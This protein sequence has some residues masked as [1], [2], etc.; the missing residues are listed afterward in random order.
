MTDKNV[1]ITI[2]ELAHQ[3]IANH[4]RQIFKHEAG[5]ILDKDPEDLHQMRVGT[6]RLQ[7]AIAALLWRSIY[8]NSFLKTEQDR[9]LCR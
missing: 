8:K 7:S 9:N 5:V 6:R 3:A 1:V 4:S 2:A